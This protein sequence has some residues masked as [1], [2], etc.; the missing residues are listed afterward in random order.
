M[1]LRKLFVLAV[2]LGVFVLSACAPVA[3]AYVKLDPA[4][5]DW[6]LYGATILVGIV[7]VQLSQVPAVIRLLEFFHI[8]PA[9]IEQY[10]FAASAWLAGIVIQFVQAGILDKIPQMW[11]NV[12]T[13]VMQLIVAVIVTLYSFHVFKRRGVQGFR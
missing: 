10:K 12:V 8:D 5:A 3:A 2:V 6:V 7:F 1:K 9:K 13:L 11:D 4:L